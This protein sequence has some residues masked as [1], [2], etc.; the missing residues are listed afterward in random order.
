M[1][2]VLI[3]VPKALELIE[4]AVKE[5]GEDWVYPDTG[6]CRY[7]YNPEDYDQHFGDE[8]YELSQD[9]LAMVAYFGE[10]QAPACLVGLVM[11]TLDERFDQVMLI[12]NDNS[13]DGWMGDGPYVQTFESVEYEFS[14]DTIRLLAAA[15]SAQ[16]SGNPWGEALSRAHSAAERFGYH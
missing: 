3:D 14:H 16:D 7:I 6:Q 1:T 10:E 8:E 15:Q 12:Q 5:R 9:E 11:H 2:R 13:V 4:A